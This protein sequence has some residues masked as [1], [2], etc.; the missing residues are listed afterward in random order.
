MHPTGLAAFPTLNAEEQF[1]EP[2]NR[3]KH[4]TLGYRTGGP[5]PCH[6]LCQGELGERC[7]RT[8]TTGHANGLVAPVLIADRR[9][10]S[11]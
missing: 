10:V 9:I 6:S 5:N 7:K 3:I 11:A 1:A 2:G 4:S 8:T